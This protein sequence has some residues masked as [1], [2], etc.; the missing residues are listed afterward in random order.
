M[1]RRSRISH[2]RP[3]SACS[4]GVEKNYML[5]GRFYP[6]PKKGAEH[7]TGR[8]AFY[9]GKAGLKVGVPPV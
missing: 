4:H 7:L 9:V 1:A 8:V 6:T 5:T 2:G 3:I